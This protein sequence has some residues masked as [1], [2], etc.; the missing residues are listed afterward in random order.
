MAYLEL[1]ENYGGTNYYSSLA[2][3]PQD[4][5]IFVPND[6]TGESGMYVREDYFD[7]LSPLE[8]EQ[9]MEALAPYQPEQ[10]S[11]I[12]SGMRERIAERRE[13]R[14]ER[15]DAR[16]EKRVARA[17]TGLFGGKLKSF[18]GG[19]IPGQ[20]PQQP[21]PSYQDPTRDFQIGFTD[22]QPTFWDKN[23]MWIIPAGAVVLVGGVYLLTKKKK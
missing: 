22:V 6:S 20:D 9:T 23:K 17:G 21:A 7:N 2:E 13:R 14:T 8:W 5:Y 11:G 15:K 1:A 18:I 16:Q 19:L 10:L 4:L 3:D 12:F